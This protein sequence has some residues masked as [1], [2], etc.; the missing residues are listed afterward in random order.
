MD[1]SLKKNFSSSQFPLLPLSMQPSHT[2][3]RRRLLATIQIQ[4]SSLSPSK[5]TKAS[6][7]NH[8][9]KGNSDFSSQ[10]IHRSKSKQ[11]I[12]ISNH[13]PEKLAPLKKNDRTNQLQLISTSRIAQ[14]NSIPSII[15]SISYKSVPGCS[16]GRVKKQNQ[17]SFFSIPNFNSSK[18]QTLLGVL[19]GHGTYGAQVS[20]YIRSHLTSLLESRIYSD[21]NP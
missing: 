3:S 11:L 4:P 1:K 21:R 17:D 15:S 18:S 16:Y 10:L 8:F 14:P 6:S 2:S 20:S 19:D 5:P 13:S 12:T 9:T 7:L